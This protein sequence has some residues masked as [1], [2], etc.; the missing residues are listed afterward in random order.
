MCNTLKLFKIQIVHFL[1]KLKINDVIKIAWFPVLIASLCHL[2]PVI[3]VFFGL[4]SVA[5][6]TSLSREL[7]GE[8]VWAFRTLG[9][10]FLVVSLVHYFHKKGIKTCNQF[11]GQLNQIINF[12]LITFFAALLSYLFLACIIIKYFYTYLRIT[13]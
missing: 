12:S 4:S 13:I 2:S 9:L 3:L 1:F 5:F 8:Y 10:I 11:K 6:A 7:C